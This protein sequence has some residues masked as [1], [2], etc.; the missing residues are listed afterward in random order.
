MTVNFGR[1]SSALRVPLFYAE[2]DNSRANSGTG[3]GRTLI[4]GQK[5]ATGAAPADT[6]LQVRG[7]SDARVQF[8]LGSILALMVDWYRK[9]DSFGDVYALP[10]A[11][12]GSGAAASGTIVF[13][14]TT[15]AAG[16]LS[17][18]VGG[19]LVPVALANGAAASAVATAV[20]AAVN[21]VSDLP[22]TAASST[23]T[24]TLT[25]KN[26]GLCGNDIDVRL[27]YLG[28]AAGEITPA[29]IT[30]TI[31]ALSGG[32]INPS[33]TTALANLGDAPFDFIVLPYTDATSLAAVQ[34]LMNDTSGRWSW[35]SQIYGHVF[36][37]YRGTT[38]ARTTFGT[39]RNNQHETVVGYFDSPTPSFCYAANVAAAA[40]NSLRAD[41]AQPLQTLQL[42]VLAPP[43]ASRDTLGQR[44]ALLYSGVSTTTVGGDGTVAIENLITTYQSNSLGQPDDSYLQVETLFTLAA[45]LRRLKAR[46]A[47]K[48]SR[49][50]LAADGTR[51]PPGAN[52]VTPNMIRADII[53]GYQ[54]MEGDL[55]ENSAAFAA[56][57]VVE[58]DANNPRRVNVL[59][60]P[61][62]I[63]Q[64][65]VLA[66][67]AQ[68]RA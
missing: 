19:R 7:G 1:I 58:R 5:T 28:Q 23:G 36:M 52:A 15:T 24:V 3:Q 14:G 4:L 32:A 22:V 59:Y 20:A 65:G 8:G 55:V 51:I 64:L 13:T 63:N 67:L 12:E 46:V 33:L 16:T 2:V 34:A 54:E 61:D 26:K 66:V 17:L 56:Q 6:P 44:N 50:K 60:P 53:A 30:P 62:L 29:G 21:A 45:I 27:N 18:Y 57:L 10:L 41:P 37:A 25:A 9:R 38:G 31:T 11:D 49:V 42:D 47:T 43:I 40:A 48:F 68:F 39:G 35:S